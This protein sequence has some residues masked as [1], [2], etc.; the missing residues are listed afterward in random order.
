[1]VCFSQEIPWRPEIK[2]EKDWGSSDY[3]YKEKWR[4][5]YLEY[6]QED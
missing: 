4:H 5:V 6:I 1:M 2:R 3:D